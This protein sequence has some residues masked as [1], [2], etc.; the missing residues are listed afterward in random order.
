MFKSKKVEQSYNRRMGRYMAAIKMQPVDRV[1]IVFNTCYYCEKKSGYNF[2]EIIYDPEKWTASETWFAEKYPEVD[3]FRGNICYAPGY[4]VVDYKL[5]RVPGREIPAVSLQQF[6]ENEWMKADEYRDFI[7][8]PIEYRMHTY[9]PR[10]L[11][12][13]TKGSIRSHVA[14]LKSGFLSGVTGAIN[15]QRAHTLK[16]EYGFP[17]TTRGGLTAPFDRL[18]DNYRGLKGIMRDMFKNPNAVL[19]ACERIMELQLSMCA[20]TADPNKQLPIFIATHKPC[21]M[22]P[23]QFDKFYWPTF[24]KGIMTMI[25]AGYTFRIFLEGNWGP[26]WDHLADFPKGTIIFDVDNEADIFDAK[27][28]FGHKNFITGGIPTDM[29]VLGSPNQVKDRIKHL[30]DTIGSNGGWSPQGGGH[31]P[32]DCKPENMQA[33]ID[34]IEEYG[35]NDGQVTPECQPAYHQ[36]LKIEGV[37]PIPVITD[38]ETFKNEHGWDILGDEEII[39]SNWDRFE[40]QAFSWIFNR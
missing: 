30:L 18:S 4:D 15:R 7:D 25:K 21:F 26:H 23:K 28:K 8:H 1:P 3:T 20:A 5:Y 14:F 38:W 37:Q 10:I 9:F 32:E 35:Y 16:Y 33:I 34:S 13:Y 31:I 17:E 19:E 22:S 40:R 2:Q 6:V 29:L 11:G 24:Y 12:E 39:K 27:E 36:D